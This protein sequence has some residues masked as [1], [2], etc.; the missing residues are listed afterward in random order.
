M[1]TGKEIITA[2]EEKRLGRLHKQ[3]MQHKRMLSQQPDA[4]DR[5][6]VHLLEDKPLR[7]KAD[8]ELLEKALQIYPLLC[9]GKTS[10]QI[11]KFIKKKD[12]GTPAT[13]YSLIRK[14]KRIFYFEDQTADFAKRGILIEMA[15]KAYNFAEKKG[16]A[17]AM[18]S[19]ANL[20]A[21]LEGALDQQQS[22][23]MIY[24]NLELPPIL[25]TDNPEAIEVPFEEVDFEE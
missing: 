12:W 18:V 23:T 7:R 10:K 9:A 15:K 13:A 17:R 22:Y 14:T 6:A 24:Q 3:T 21:K 20:L 19:A 4:F 25:I 16:D 1:S 5:I 11:I 8:R 2:R